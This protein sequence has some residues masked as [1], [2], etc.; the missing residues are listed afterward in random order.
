MDT[1]IRTKY[2]E[3]RHAL[4][5]FPAQRIEPGR[6]ELLVA[7][8]RPGGGMI[9]VGQH[10]VHVLVSIRAPREG[11]DGGSVNSFHINGKQARFREGDALQV[12]LR[13]L[14]YFY[15]V[16]ELDINGLGRT[17][18]ARDLMSDP[19]SRRP[20]QTP[21][22]KESVGRRC[23]SPSSLHDAPPCG[24]STSP[25]DRSES[26]LGSIRSISRPFKATSCAGSTLHS[27]TEFCTR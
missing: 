20:F 17:R 15:C 11:G 19:G 8:L 18:T 7:V 2:C 10:T 6:L 25:N 24:A 27:N 21:A 9:G 26:V 22:I 1:F 4:Q 13:L 3:K 23:R 12:G 5:V 16:K 14:R